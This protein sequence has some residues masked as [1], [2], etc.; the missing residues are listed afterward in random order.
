MTW[1]T[2]PPVVTISR[3]TGANCLS[4]RDLSFEGGHRAQVLFVDLFRVAVHSDALNGVRMKSLNNGERFRCSRGG[5]GVKPRR[6]ADGI[7]GRDCEERR[8]VW[9][10]DRSRGLPNADLQVKSMPYPKQGMGGFHHR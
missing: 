4:V 5:L 7:V 2:V 9:H 10:L 6:I 3:Y 1:V 8:R